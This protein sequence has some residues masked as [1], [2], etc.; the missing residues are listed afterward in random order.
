MLFRSY[1]LLKV[2]LAQKWKPGVFALREYSHADVIDKWGGRMLN[3]GEQ[4]EF[5]NIP[6]TRA[7]QEND[8]F[9]LRPAT[10]EKFFPGRLYEREEC[11]EWVEAV[12]REGDADGRGVL[13]TTPVLIAAPKEIYAEFRTWIVD[14]KAVT[15]SSYK[16]QGRLH[17]G[18]PVEDRIVEFAEDADRIWA[19]ERA[20]CLDVAATPDGLRIVEANTIN[21]AGFYAANLGKLVAAIEM[22]F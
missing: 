6:L 17:T 21:F 2:S 10:D 1:G 20:Y 5:Q 13:P 22:A 12:I 4:C 14:G 18:L 7:F 8:T 11:R 15:A 3:D 16:L 19:P 9:F